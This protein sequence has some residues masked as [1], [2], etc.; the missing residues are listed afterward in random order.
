MLTVAASGAGLALGLALARVAAAFVPA[1]ADHGPRVRRA[2]AVAVATAVVLGLLAARLGPVPELAAY[3][4]FGAGCV[5]LAA[6]DVRVRRLPDLL[7][8]PTAGALLVLLALAAAVSGSWASWGRA[9]A[10]AGVLAA[11]YLAQA[12]APGA[13][14]GLGD[15]KFAPAVGLALG[16]LGW[17][18]V[19]AGTLAAHVLGAAA[20]AL[21]AV[22]RGTGWRTTVPFGPAMALGALA[23]ILDGGHVLV[24]AVQTLAGA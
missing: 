5:V 23:V 12:A 18:E 11:V 7:T 15:V 20:G 8:L 14:L 21:L 9:V 3:L 4:V 19:L 13:G 17:A 22:V 10:A 1:P 6:V 16:W 24:R 2:C